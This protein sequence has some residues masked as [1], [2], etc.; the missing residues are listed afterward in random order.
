MIKT[1]ALFSQMPTNKH[2]AFVLAK[3]L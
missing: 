3:K 1:E 2:S